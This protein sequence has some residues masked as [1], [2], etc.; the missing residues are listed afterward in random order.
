MAWL[1]AMA[2]GAGEGMIGGRPL[3]AKS[4]DGVPLFRV[5]QALDAAGAALA[6]GEAPPTDAV[7]GM[8]RVP[9]PYMPRLIWHRLFMKGAGSCWEKQAAG[10]GVSKADMLAAPHGAPAR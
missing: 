10:H 4:V 6:R 1:G 3:E 2:M 9:I 5:S 8:A 7:Q